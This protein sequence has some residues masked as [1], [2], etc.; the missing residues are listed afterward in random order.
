MI[1]FIDKKKQTGYL[2]TF[3]KESRFF[4]VTSVEG[5]YLKP[6]QQLA[7][8]RRAVEWVDD[9]KPAPKGRKGMAQMFGLPAGIRMYFTTDKAAKTVG[10]TLTIDASR[11]IISSKTICFGRDIPASYTI[12]LALDAMRDRGLLTEEDIRENGYRFLKFSHESLTNML[13]EYLKKRKLEH[14]KIE[15]QKILKAFQ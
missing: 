10:L 9:Q 3:G 15:D 7:Q 2:A 1:Q 13:T 6:L 12:N 5:G 8:R 14:L 11:S 4:S